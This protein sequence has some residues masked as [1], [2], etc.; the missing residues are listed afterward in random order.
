MNKCQNFESALASNDYWASLVGR[1]RSFRLH[2]TIFT[3]ADNRFW[4]IPAIL[5]NSGRVLPPAQGKLSSVAV[6]IAHGFNDS[7]VDTN[8]S[9][10]CTGPSVVCPFMH[11]N[12]LI[13]KNRA[14]ATCTI[15]RHN[16][17]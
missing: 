11:G 17:A 13:R 2:W 6:T 16:P 4:S 7:V 1:G 12:A 3:S 5:R 8:D 9:K 15:G 10:E 14:R